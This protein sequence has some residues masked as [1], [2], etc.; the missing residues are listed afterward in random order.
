[1]TNHTIPTTRSS[2]PQAFSGSRLWPPLDWA[3]LAGLLVSTYLSMIVVPSVYTL[4]SRRALRAEEEAGGT[5]AT[6]AYT[7]TTA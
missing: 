5:S 3:I 4:I 1:M 6:P 2:L 7:A